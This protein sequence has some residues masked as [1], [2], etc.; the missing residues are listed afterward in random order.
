MKNNLIEVGLLYFDEHFLPYY[1]IDHIPAGFFSQRRLAIGG[2][3][4]FWVHDRNGQPFFVI[5][6]SAR[7]KLRAMIPNLIQR[8]Q[9]ITGQKKLTIVFDRCGYDI[10]SF[11][12]INGFKTVTFISV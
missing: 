3:H 2:N 7:L 10:K 5:T 1:G 4:Q 12:T 8:A 11:E 9:E 6:T